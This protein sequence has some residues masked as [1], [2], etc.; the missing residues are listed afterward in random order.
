M[1]SSLSWAV[2]TDQHAD[3]GRY[4]SFAAVFVIERADM[5]SGGGADH[6]VRAVWAVK[7]GTDACN[8]G[9]FLG[10]VKRSV[11]CASESART[12]QY[13]T[14]GDATADRYEIDKAEKRGKEQCTS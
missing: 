7:L 2:F 3:H 12:S 6:K 9:M 4:G 11:I 5:G 8:F 14:C 10:I 1:V 13:H